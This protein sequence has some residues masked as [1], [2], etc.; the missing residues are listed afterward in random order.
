MKKVLFLMFLLLLM[1]LGAASVKAQVRIGGNTPPS[2][3]AV[4]DLNATDAT[5]TGTKTLALPRVSLT[6]AT[7]LMGNASL[8]T[9]MLVYN[10]TATPGVGVY[11][12]DGGKWVKVLDGSFVE[13]DAVI[14][15]EVTDATAGGGLTRSG[16][17]TATS[18]YTLGIS[19]GG[20]TTSM[21]ADG[22]IYSS[23]IANGTIVGNDI[24][25]NTV[26]S[27]NI[28]MNGLGLYN[29][30]YQQSANSYLIGNVAGA[31]IVEPNPLTCPTSNYWASCF[32]DGGCDIT[33]L[34]S[35]NI[36]ITRRTAGSVQRVDIR[37][38][39]F[40]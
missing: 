8:L 40:N 36:M 26:N 11:Y 7:D 21:I 23:K 39:C 33:W 12:W 4:L 13:G 28:V 19:T 9:G 29:L 22:S 37:L 34:T 3:A 2:A 18:P 27:A 24:A 25:A 1:G 10:T 31:Y 35:G 14:G 5:N 15:N 6:S 17:G 20:V 38:F 16:L 32:S 30:S